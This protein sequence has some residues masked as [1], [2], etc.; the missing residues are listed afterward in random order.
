MKIT[1]SK[2]REMVKGMLRES[3]V[4]GMANGKTIA[5]IEKRTVDKNTMGNYG[6]VEGEVVVIKFTDETELSL[7]SNSIIEDEDERT[8]QT[9]IKSWI[10]LSNS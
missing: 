8:G 7:M 3:S 4:T 2:L 1:E 5:N 10:D 9:F 6:E